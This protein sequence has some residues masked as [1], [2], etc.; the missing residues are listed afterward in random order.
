ML[1]GPTSR[2][3]SSSSTPPQRPI[4]QHPTSL[5]ITKSP[6]TPPVATHSSTCLT[7]FHTPLS[8]CLLC[9]TST[10]VA[11]HTPFSPLSSL[12]STCTMRFVRRVVHT[13]PSPT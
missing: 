11:P 12:T 1:L 13:A 4:S 8:V 3:S 10:H 2:R 5:S 7:R 9:L 6:P